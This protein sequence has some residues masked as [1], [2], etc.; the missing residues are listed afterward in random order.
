MGKMLKLYL[1]PKSLLVFG[2]TFFLGYY[3]AE[4]YVRN[5]KSFQVSSAARTPAAPNFTLKNLNGETV[6]LTDFRGKYVFL[7]FWAT[8]C[9]PCREEMPSMDSL[10][11]KFRSSN[12]FE[13]LAV[14]LDRQGEAVVKPFVNKYG[15]SYPI[16]L[17]EENRTVENYGVV[18]I[19]STFILSPEGEIIE[20]IFGSRDWSRDEV[21]LFFDELLNG[22]KQ[23][24]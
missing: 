14:S 5:P 15:F 13:M 19:P 8:W 24:V 23:P 12:R 18:S 4:S 16:L 20:K 6:S 22:Q 11:R 21:F 3:L 10:Y 9:F 1:R 2:L 7:N 17:D